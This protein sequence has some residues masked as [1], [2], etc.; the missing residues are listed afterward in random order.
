MD[1][2]QQLRAVYNTLNKITVAGDANIEYLY[3]CFV[4]LSQVIKEMESE[5]EE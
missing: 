3:G 2:L 4:T 1:K 5:K